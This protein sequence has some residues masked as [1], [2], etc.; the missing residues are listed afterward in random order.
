M[1]EQ[2][3]A[4]RQSFEKDIQLERNQF[5]A[6]EN[7]LVVRSGQGVDISGLGMGIITKFPLSPRETIRVYLPVDDMGFTLPV[8]SEVRWITVQN[9]NYR[10][11]LQFLR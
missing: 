2:R 8:F 10:A 9:N 7:S 6:R 3:S 1:A 5:Y 11:G 4:S